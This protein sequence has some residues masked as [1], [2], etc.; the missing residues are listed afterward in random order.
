MQL[1]LALPVLPS[2]HDT[3]LPDDEQQLH[4][5]DDDDE[6]LAAQ[7]TAA[8][9]SVDFPDLG[10][11][12][13]GLP[14]LHLPLAAVATVDANSLRTSDVIQIYTFL[15]GY[16][17]L[18]RTLLRDLPHHVPQSLPETTFTTACG[19]A[20]R[21]STAKHP[22]AYGRRE[23]VKHF[24]DFLES[25]Y[26]PAEVTE[27]LRAFWSIDAVDEQ[28]ATKYQLFIHTDTQ[29]ECQMS[30]YVACFRIVRFT[31]SV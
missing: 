21:Y 2:I 20:P 3:L 22:D 10:I 27:D 6:F 9:D 12:F 5:A 7:L 31:S 26:D 18:A 19:W 4:E 24:L 15:L 30:C 13:N 23:G 14:T 25:R 29:N 28:G 16:A 17:E 11:F 1:L 8:M